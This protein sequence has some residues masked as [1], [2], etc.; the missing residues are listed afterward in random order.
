MLDIS[1][2][3]LKFAL[4]LMRFDFDIQYIKGHQNAISSALSRGLAI[5][6]DN[7]YK[8]VR[9]ISVAVKI[10]C[11]ISTDEYLFLLLLPPLLLLPLLRLGE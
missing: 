10:G 2:R 8:I 1:P 6:E 7:L 9:R 11:C 5:D 3:L 4:K